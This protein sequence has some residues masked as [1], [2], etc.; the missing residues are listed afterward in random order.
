ME[1]QIPYRIIIIAP[2]LCLRNYP[3]RK[4]PSL[5]LLVANHTRAITLRRR[6]LWYSAACHLRKTPSTLESQKATKLKVS[7]KVKEAVY[8]KWRELLTKHFVAE[9]LPYTAT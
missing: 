2:H 5:H 9:E 1:L 3:S 4:N 8:T 7:R 6:H